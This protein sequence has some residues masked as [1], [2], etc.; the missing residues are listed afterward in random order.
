MVARL[1]EGLYPAL[2][3]STLRRVSA[4]VTS[5]PASIPSATTTPPRWHGWARSIAEFLIVGGLT[6]IL[7]VV[8]WVLQRR[9]GLEA[10]ELAVSFA[11]FYA[12]YVINDPHFAVTY[13]LFY[14]DVRA[15]AFGTAFSPGQRLRYVLMGFI[16]PLALFAWA[17]VGLAMRSAS[18]LGWMFKLMYFLVGWHYV[19]QG[20]GVMMVLSARRGVSYTKAERIIILVHAF[21]GWAFSWAN[22]AGP[23]FEL[24]ERGVIYMGIAHPRWLERGAQ[25]VLYASGV[26]LFVALVLKW[27][28]ERRF[29]I[30]TPLFALLVSVWSWLIYS[31]SDPLVRYM[32]P[33]LHSIQYLYFVGLI[34]RNEAK[35]RERAPWFERS[36]RVRL[37]ILV[38]SALGLGWLFFHVGPWALDDGLIPAGDRFSSL[39]ATPYAA[40]IYTFVNIHHYCMDYVIWRRE[41][42]LT[43]YLVMR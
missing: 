43:R 2:E 10:S 4:S 1:T 21:A 3:P 26:A 19:K 5:L 28:R 24:E 30:V 14:R 13:V 11:F 42:P 35:E 38:A 15:R 36:A 33:A 40:A 8:S 12:A 37:G 18:T 22:P 20:F 6:P 34:S 41:N 9:F 7:F 39:G 32:I 31:G 23:G 29:P 16:V 25:G 27:R 17:F